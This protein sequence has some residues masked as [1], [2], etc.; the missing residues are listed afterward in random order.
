MTK[1]RASRREQVSV[2]FFTS[3]APV[4][5]QSTTT[6]KRRFQLSTE[7]ASVKHV[8]S[9]T[10]PDSDT[11]GSNSLA[12]LQLFRRCSHRRKVDG[13]QEQ[14]FMALLAH[15]TLLPSTQGQRRAS[16][17]TTARMRAISSR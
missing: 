4:A 9:A 6:S 8:W 2:R 3:L 12:H 17:M 5:G 13:E 10:N 16:C 1:N 11:V 15:Q 14:L 7:L